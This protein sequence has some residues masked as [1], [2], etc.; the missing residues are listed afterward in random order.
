MAPDCTANMRVVACKEQLQG[1]E[2]GWGGS[3]R[4]RNPS[5]KKGDRTASTSGMGGD[6]ASKSE[7]LQQS[8]HAGVGE[9]WLGYD[10]KDITRPE[11]MKMANAQTWVFSPQ[12]NL[13]GSANLLGGKSATR[14]DDDNGGQAN[15]T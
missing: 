2:Q 7:R 9:V 8:R 12:P 13:L 4:R 11:Y 6:D 5:S 10:G 1:V 15:R 3:I 14:C